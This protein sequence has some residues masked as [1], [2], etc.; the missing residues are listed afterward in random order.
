MSA[1]GSGIAPS[2]CVASTT[3]TLPL[4]RAAAPTG[5]RSIRAPFVQ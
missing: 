4:A 2:D 1:I 3:S 5:T